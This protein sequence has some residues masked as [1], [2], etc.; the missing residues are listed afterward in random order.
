MIGEATA[1]RDQHGHAKYYVGAVTDITELRAAQEA[2]RHTEN[3]AAAGRM[4]ARIAH[5]INNPLAGIKNSFL[6]IKDA[7]SPQHNTPIFPMWRVSRRKSTAFCPHRLAQMLDMYR[8]DQASPREFKISEAILD[9]VAFLEPGAKERCIHIKTSLP[10]VQQSVLLPESS[11]RIILYNVLQNAIEASPP[12]GVV[13]VEAA[14]D[15]QLAIRIS[16]HGSG[17]PAPIA[18]HIFEPFFTTKHGAGNRGGLGLGLS[19]SRSLIE[20]MKGTIT[21][22][23]SHAGTT[24]QIQIPLHNPALE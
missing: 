4:S 21:F 5:E 8:P 11:L 17:I 13:R 7:V 10:D 20:A 16:D 18:F 15:G 19:T 3:L 24:F 6:L 22:D 2:L 9:V 1:S 14:V 23:S 12:G